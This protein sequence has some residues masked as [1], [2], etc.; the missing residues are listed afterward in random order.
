MKKLL[1]WP[2]SAALLLSACD[3]NSSRQADDARQADEKRLADLRAAEQ[4]A[5][6]REDAAKAAET[7]LE[8]QR[9][10]DARA[11][12]E[13]DRQKLEAEK[14]S[15]QDDAEKLAR[16]RAREEKL[17]ERRKALAAEER[18]ERPREPQAEGGSQTGYFYTALESMGDWLQVE[19]YGY[20]WQP[21]E[22]GDPDWRPYTDGTWVY[23]DSGWTW[24]SNERFGWATYHF[25]RWTRLRG[26][27]WVWVPGTEWAPAWVSWRHGGDYVGWAP[28][29][30]EAHA[31]GGF[32]ASVDTDYDIGPA[33]YNFLPT[34]SVGEP[35]YRGVLVAPAQNVTI[36]NQTVNVTK[37]NYTT[38]NQTKVVYIGGP[39]LN[40][41]NAVSARP[42]PQAT[43]QRVTEAPATRPGGGA[44][45]L[46][47]NVLQVSAPHIAAAPQAAAAPAKVRQ[48]VKAQVEHGWSGG[49]PQAVQAARDHV[50]QQA[51][52]APPPL[53]QKPTAMAT[54]VPQPMA[55]TP[56]PPQVN[57]P[58]RTPATPHATRPP[59]PP[60]AT[61][62]AA[63][64][65]AVPPAP[66]REPSVAATPTIERPRPEH[67]PGAPAVAM[68]PHLKPATPAPLPLEHVDTAPAVIPPA[69][70]RAT[71]EPAAPKAT[72]GTAPQAPPHLQLERFGTP[73]PHAAG[74]PRPK[75]SPGEKRGATPVPK[76]G[77]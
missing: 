69:M 43:L 1:L 46:N 31:G 13:S 40:Q 36:I 5:A 47:G 41:I 71:H 59:A 10:A 16:W 55:A 60:K 68:T 62:A 67:P 39:T 25:G 30:P 22:A 61:P 34:R 3:R 63:A 6:Q 28:L 38:V 51:A 9:L 7:D 57:E 18:E 37:I 50:R 48:T 65:P 44:A 15:V 74:T 70:P 53:A 64:H 27:G 72:P 19:P 29:P 66:M 26:T 42:V 20:A 52:H 12:L 21:R 33:L 76:E 32:T 2:L 49:D 17:A 24:K 54:P 11:A 4:S 73:P 45:V 75:G 35:T 58:A 23:T 14:A 56:P 77:L 8:R